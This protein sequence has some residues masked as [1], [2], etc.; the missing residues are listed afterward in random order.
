MHARDDD[1][2]INLFRVRKHV[3]GLPVC[4]WGAAL[5]DMGVEGQKWPNG[6]AATHLKVL[7]RCGQASSNNKS[8]HNLHTLADVEERGAAGGRGKVT[9]PPCAVQEPTERRCAQPRPNKS[10]H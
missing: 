4:Q 7:H 6:H 3:R 2:C 5:G 10:E 9:C 8:L 1:V